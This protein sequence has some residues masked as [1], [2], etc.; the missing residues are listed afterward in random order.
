MCLDICRNV[1]LRLGSVPNIEDNDGLGGIGVEADV[2]A[3]T[4]ELGIGADGEAVTTG[5]VLPE[6]T[7]TPKQ[8]IFIIFYIVFR[9]EFLPDS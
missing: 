7:I 1:E 6:F 3:T 4:G 8:K 9:V 5:T 2:V